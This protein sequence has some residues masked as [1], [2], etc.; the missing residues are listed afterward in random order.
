MPAPASELSPLAGQLRRLLAIV[1]ASGRAFLPG[2]NLELLNSIVEAAARIFGAAA[3]SIALVDEQEDLSLEAA[4]ER[5]SELFSGLAT[6]ADFREGTRDFL[7]KR[8]P[9]FIGR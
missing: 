4:L 8:K 2:T 7:E 1:E 6:T 9:G 5:E 3:A